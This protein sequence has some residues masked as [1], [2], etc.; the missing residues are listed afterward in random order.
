MIKLNNKEVDFKIFPNGESFA[1]MPIDKFCVVNGKSPEIFFKFENDEDLFYLS[2]VKDYVDN[3]WPN[4][5]CTLIMPYIPYSRMD[6]Q[7]ETRLFTLKTFAK[8]I[9][10]MNFSS[11]EVWEPHSDVSIALI[12]RVKVNTSQRQW[13][14]TGMK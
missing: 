6:R 13:V 4:E 3:Y 14:D 11:V 1:D 12:D 10:S 5:P 9:N 7:E 8:I 2:C